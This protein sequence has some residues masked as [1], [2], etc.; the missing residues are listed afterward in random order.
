MKDNEETLSTTLAQIRA[1]KS[2][3]GP[4]NSATLASALS[5]EGTMLNLW[6]RKYELQQSLELFN[7]PLLTSNTSQD[8]GNQIVT[9][10][11]F[12]EYP[13]QE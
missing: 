10:N 1:L 2:F 4:V 5:E 11:D 6:K 8:N 9:K 13:S 3:Y 7:Q 12:W